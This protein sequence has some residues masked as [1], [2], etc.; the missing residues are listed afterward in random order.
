MEIDAIKKKVL[1]DVDPRLREEKLKQARRTR[2]VT[3]VE[4]VALIVFLVVI[5]YILMGIATVDGDSMYPTLHN[6]DKVVYLRRVSEYQAGD[7]I[8]L[9][10]PNGEEYVKRIV[11][12]AGDTVN[13][14]EGKLYVNGKETE[15]KEALGE[16]I[17][18]SDHVQYPVEVGE[19]EVFVLGDNREISEDS[20]SFGSVDIS[21][22]AGKLMF[23][24]GRVR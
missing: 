23:Y 7:I 21:N 11:A 12:I 1:E 2:L 17:W 4:F 9:N 24:V 22:I 14:Q 20:R 13:I 16:S 3:S 8:V 15:Y 6:K 19:S 18:M 5:F 10:R